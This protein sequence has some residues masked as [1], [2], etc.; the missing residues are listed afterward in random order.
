MGHPNVVFI[1]SDQQRA[2]DAGYMGNPDVKTPVMDA[3]SKQSVVF[4][5]AVSGHPVCSPYRASLI[6][7]QYSLT[8]KVIANNV[9]LGNDAVSLAQAYSA[10]GYETAYIG[11][12]HIDGHGARSN[13]I[14]KERRQGFDFWRVLECTHDY[15]NSYYYGDEN[16]KLKW[17][18][19]DAE[20]QTR[21]A[22][23]YIKSRNREK[24]FL[25]V[26]SWGPPH[27][28]YETAPERFKALYDPQ[29]LTLRPN[30]PP[31]LAKQTGNELAGYYAHISALDW[32]LGEMLKTIDDEGLAED[33]LLVYTSDHG[34]M[35]GSQGASRKQH[36]WDESILVPF[37]LRYPA[38]L[39]RQR[40][41]ISMPI[42][43]PDIMPTLLELSGLPIPSTVEG[44]SFRK[45]ITGEKPEEDRA[46]FIQCPHPFGEFTKLE[47]GR[48]YRGVRTMR[49]TYT[50]DLN[51]PWLLYDNME[52]PYQMKNLIGVP[53]YKELAEK[54]DG[55][56]QS[57]L[58][59]QGDKFLTGEHYMNL[60]GYPMNERG[61]VPYTP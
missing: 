55:E 56:L 57:I 16:I 48:E 17:D 45:Y 60:F 58:D 2:Q 37:M 49:Y 36:P 9:C 8:H 33:T 15:N 43:T 39:G 1:F 20:A 7:G 42:N 28:P 23:E 41:E 12:W 24:P 31:E 3:L 51:G 54:L 44:M 59:K 50:R 10:G 38:L 22:Q 52:D 30:V 21:C 26:M 18:G 6:T 29:S 47:S 19:Y 53:G 46:A 14:P 27:N 13:F 61:V 32:L 35:L 11:K 4:R 5:H 40:R 34:D 25:L